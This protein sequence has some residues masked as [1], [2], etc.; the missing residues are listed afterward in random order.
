MRTTTLNVEAHRHC[1]FSL[2]FSTYAGDSDRCRPDAN[3][4]NTPDLLEMETLFRQRP[5]TFL[6]F[7]KGGAKFPHRIAD[8]GAPLLLPVACFGTAFYYMH[9]CVA[10]HC[11]RAVDEASLE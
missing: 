4:L 9:F 8:S 1:F 5:D 3:Y 7:C 11:F 2:G 6:G 10:L